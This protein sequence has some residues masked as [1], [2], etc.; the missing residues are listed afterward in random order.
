MVGLVLSTQA[1]LHREFVNHGIC[2]GDEFGAGIPT[3]RGDAVQL[4]QIPLNIFMNAMD[5]MENVT[6]E[7]RTIFISVDRSKEGGY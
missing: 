3:V 6:L 2:V 4:L 5:A 1:L 7:R